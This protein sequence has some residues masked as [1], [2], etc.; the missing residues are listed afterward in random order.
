[1]SKRSRRSFD[2]EFKKRVVQ[3]YL[4]G[5][6]SAQVI[7]EREGLEQGQIYRWKIQLEEKSREERIGVLASEP[8]ASPEQARKMQELEEQLAATQK[9]LAA[10]SVENELLSEFVKKTDPNSAYARRSSSF[11]DIR[12][13]LVRSKGRAK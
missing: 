8:G 10:L 7:S 3:E 11:A 12:L 2:L 4:R 9:K 13:A 6:E 5:E 1:M